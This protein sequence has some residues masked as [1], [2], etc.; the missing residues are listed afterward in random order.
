MTSAQTRQPETRLRQ[1]LDLEGR[2]PSWLARQCGVAPSTVTGW[3]NGSISPRKRNM[4]QAAKALGRSVYDVWFASIDSG[5][6]F[7]SPDRPV[8]SEHFTE[9]STA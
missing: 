4:E 8:S 6:A 9:E 7:F 3:M 2:R 5:E 1:I